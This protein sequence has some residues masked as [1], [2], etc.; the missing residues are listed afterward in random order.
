MSAKN[1]EQLTLLDVSEE[2]PA[3]KKFIAMRALSRARGD[4][5][6]EMHCL[7]CLVFQTRAQREAFVAALPDVA[8]MHHMYADGVA[9]CR[10]FGIEIPAAELRPFQSSMD[11]ALAAQTLKGGDVQWPKRE[12]KREVAAAREAEAKEGGAER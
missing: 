5:K 11:A 1:K 9:F 10:R 12:A 8:I 2:N 7:V 4:D 6:A 3:L